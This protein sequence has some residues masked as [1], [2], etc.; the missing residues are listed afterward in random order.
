MTTTDELLDQLIADNK[1]P[2]DLIGPAD[3]LHQLDNDALL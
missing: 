3:S 1:K 2:E